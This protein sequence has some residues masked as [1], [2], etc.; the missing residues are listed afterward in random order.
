MKRLLLLPLAILRL[1]FTSTRLA[2]GQIWANKTRSVLT[3]IGIVIGVASVTA[4]IAVLTGFQRKILSQIESFGS[5]SIMVQS[6]RPDS[7]PLS[8]AQWWT[9][10]FSG[11]E[12]DDILKHC[13]SVETIC[14]VSAI[15]QHT[16]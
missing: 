13:P 16:V 5:N 10:R 1:I 7:G 3:S 15:G 14:R 9:I 2:L 11:D 6:R 12:F 4:V 8:K